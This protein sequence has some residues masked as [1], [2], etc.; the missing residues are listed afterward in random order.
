MLFLC[1][2]FDIMRYTID[3]TANEP[4]M[5]INTH[6]GMDSE[7]GM[8]VDG[9]EF[10][11]ELL[12][13]DSLNKDKIHIWINSVGGVIMDGYNIISAILNTKTPIYTHNVGIAASIA[14]VIFACGEKRKSMDYALFM[15]HPPQGGNPN[16]E[17]SI[18]MQES[19]VSLLSSKSNLP[20]ESINDLMNLDSWLNAN[21]CLSSGI[22]TEIESSKSDI[23]STTNYLDILKEAKQLTNKLLKPN[24][25]IMQKLTNKLGLVDGANEDSI[26]DAIVKQ[27]NKFNV[28]R[29]AIKA[30]VNALTLEKET[31]E[32]EI[33][34]S[35]KD[36]ETEK[37]TNVIKGFAT[38][39]QIKDDEETIAKWVNFAKIDL[40]G[41][42]EVLKG[43]PI[44]KVANK[45]EVKPEDTAFKGSYLQEKM[46]EITNKTNK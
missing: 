39:G 11:R 5:L 13:L 30:Q 14:G 31:L 4:I 41:T 18:K 27:E 34:Q 46:A 44:N 43:L 6:I 16:S 12:E 38:S 28:E 33:E 7:D 15:T 20:K 36:A 32:G 8:G 25:N 26:L 45:I 2:I 23:K 37:V 1:L 42:V 24:T 9:A 35:K 19:L 21:E 22:C 10:Q 17:M 3:S 40:D 29:E